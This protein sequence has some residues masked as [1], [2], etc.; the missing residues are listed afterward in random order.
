L[1]DARLQQVG[2]PREIYESPANLFV[3][4]FIGQN[5][6]LSGRVQG[7]KGN[8]SMV[9]LDTGQVIT[10]RSNGIPVVGN[11]VLV[12]VRPEKITMEGCD[13]NHLNSLQGTV[14]ELIYFGDHFRVCVEV[15][16]QGAIMVIH[17]QHMDGIR[18]RPGL[19]VQLKWEREH[20]TML[21]ATAS[22]PLTM[23]SH[24]PEKDH[25]KPNNF[26]TWL[27]GA[28][29]LLRSCKGKDDS[30]KLI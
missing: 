9:K 14:T 24:I 2:T 6:I 3:A 20:C 19:E 25:S 29:E 1:H 7:L 11:R 18:V 23:R 30:R 5:N 17:R 10:T 22:S 8:A 12:C 4:Q 15:P 13:G 27:S 28:F 26:P 16:G 21:E